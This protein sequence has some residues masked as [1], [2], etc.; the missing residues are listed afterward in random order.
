MTRLSPETKT[1]CIAVINDLDANSKTGFGVITVSSSST[2]GVSWSTRL[3]PATGPEE[4]RRSGHNGHAYITS[5]LQLD[6]LHSGFLWFTEFFPSASSAPGL[7]NQNVILSDTGGFLLSFHSIHY[8]CNTGDYVSQMYFFSHFLVLM[9][10]V[11]QC[12]K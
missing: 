4:I 1:I 5:I 8:I 11:D 7:Y 12:C 10:S 9:E 2:S 6:T 3:L